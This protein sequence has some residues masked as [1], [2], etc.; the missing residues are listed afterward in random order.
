M[1][2]ERLINAIENLYDWFPDTK[3]SDKGWKRVAVSYIRSRWMALCDEI[4]EKHNVDA[5]GFEPKSPLA[6][7]AAET[8]REKEKQEM[9]HTLYKISASQSQ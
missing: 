7:K 6:P 8:D 9:A 4:K 5:S 1:S 2:K 3:T